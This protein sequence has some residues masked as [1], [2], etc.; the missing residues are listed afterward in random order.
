M[1]KTPTTTTTPTT[2]PADPSA[3]VAA[4]ADTMTCIL[5][6]EAEMDAV[7]QRVQAAIADNLALSKADLQLI[8]SALGSLL[9]LQGQLS[10]N[11]VTLHKLRKLVGLVSASEK[12]RGLIKPGQ[13]EDEENGQQ[14]DQRDAKGANGQSPETHEG[15][16]S[17]DSGQGDLAKPTRKPRANKPP[18]NT[19]PTR[20]YHALSELKK[21]MRCPECGRGTL[22]KY[23]PAT[24][25][26]I[27]GHT[28]FS[29]H[30][31]VMERLRCNACQAYQTATPSADVLADGNVGQHY[32]YSARALMC[33]NKFDNGA[34][35]ARQDSLQNLSGE[36]INA[37]SLVDQWEQ[38]ANAVQPVFKAL[39]LLTGNAEIIM[40]DDTGNNILD[41][42]GGTQKPDRRSGILKSRTGIYS[43]GVL[44]CLPA[45]QQT[46]L[47]E[48]NIGHAGEWLDS[49]LIHRDPD[50][51][52]V[53]LMSDALSSNAPTQ[54]DNAII[55]LCNVHARREFADLIV[56]FESEV[57]DQLGDYA[58]I[59]FNENHVKKAKLSPEARRD[60]H[61]QH[62]LPVMQTMRDAF[63]KSL[64]TEAVEENSGLGKAMRYFIK[65]Y[66][67]LTRF[68]FE[69]NMPL[70]NNAMEAL[71]KIIIRNRK[72]ALF[73]KT[74][75]GAAIGD[76]LT[77]MIAT[78]HLNGVNP[79]EYLIQLQSHQDAVKADPMKW[80]PWNY[81]DNRQ[82]TMEA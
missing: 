45:G 52:P 9:Y 44:G 70:D 19:P 58:Q 39:C 79:Y 43:S 53:K 64:E 59:W 55:G 34:P 49:L 75:V 63:Q 40:L 51:P 72:N 60:Y 76:V 16:D 46:A 41:Q 69:V 48:T 32:G 56:N 47:F 7:L 1:T 27:Q 8:L 23:Q 42:Q 37:S 61:Q 71:L 2:E 66:H 28:P 78:C 82:E 65:H 50:A 77:S 80:L 17:G 10:D 30:R 68:C 31:H 6:S 36:P 12:L 20:H 33:L 18:R 74:Q 26:R 54:V 73:F 35:S 14:D 38:A 62:S 22:Y 3:K 21:G 67:G 25:L 29:A 5:L 4:A 13:D 57:V 11:R 24:F 81:Q 15:E